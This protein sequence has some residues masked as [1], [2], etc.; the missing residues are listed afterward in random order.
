MG[1]AEEIW[2]GVYGVA[3]SG[4]PAGDGRWL[5]EFLTK[6]RGTTEEGSFAASL[7]TGAAQDEELECVTVWSG[8]ERRLCF[9]AYTLPEARF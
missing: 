2:E 7:K 8:Y 9:L 4:G 5:S 1:V 3:E 6:F